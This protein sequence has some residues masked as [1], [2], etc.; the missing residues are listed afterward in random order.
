MGTCLVGFTSPPHALPPP[1]G[2]HGTNTSPHHKTQLTL[3][4]RPTDIMSESEDGMEE[5]DEPRG[6]KGT[7]MAEQ[8]AEDVDVYPARQDAGMADASNLMTEVTTS[9]KSCPHEC[10]IC[11]TDKSVRS[12]FRPCC[13]PGGALFMWQFML[14]KHYFRNNLGGKGSPKSLTHRFW[15]D[16]YA[17][18]FLRAHELGLWVRAWIGQ[19]HD[20]TIGWLLIT[21]MRRSLAGN[22]T[23]RDCVLEGRPGIKRNLFL[24]TYILANALKALPQRTT[25]NGN[26]LPPRP[27]KPAI[28]IY[29]MLWRI[30]FIFRPCIDTPQEAPGDADPAS[31]TTAATVG[32]TGDVEPTSPTEAEG[33]DAAEEASDGGHSPKPKET[34]SANNSGKDIDDSG[35]APAAES[36]RKPGTGTEEGKHE[37]NSSS[38]K[39]NDHVVARQEQEQGKEQDHGQDDEQ[40]DDQ[41]D[42]QEQ[43]HKQMEEVI[44]QM[45]INV[46]QAIVL[47]GKAKARA[48]KKSKNNR[49]RDPAAR[50]PGMRLR[51]GD[52]QRQPRSQPTGTMA[53]VKAAPSQNTL[54]RHKHSSM[55]AW[56]CVMS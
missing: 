25:R 11:I 51:G 9:L 20:T 6:T 1:V 12:K 33:A 26:I 41:D 4:P 28:T 50:V 3:K 42:E 27:A 2:E 22:I 31:V 35:A 17:N 55:F 45:K 15:T 48:E 32:K 16:E 49:H 52:V 29:T 21:S 44:A 23:A 30:E 5:E 18:P 43:E 56:V 38:V 34:E 14:F 10:L 13:I 39:S 46:A 36:P 54:T 8:G 7:D 47:A 53:I 40:D 19:G 37:I 24:K